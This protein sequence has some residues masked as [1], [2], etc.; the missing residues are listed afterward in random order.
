MHTSTLSDAIMTK[1]FAIKFTLKSG[2][3]TSDWKV[4]PGNNLEL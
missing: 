3:Q 2:K 4:L 1:W